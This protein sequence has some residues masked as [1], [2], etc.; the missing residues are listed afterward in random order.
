MGAE[1][2]S[3]VRSKTESLK[4]K[5]DEME[6]VEMG[7]D[8]HFTQLTFHLWFQTLL[9]TRNQSLMSKVKIRPCFPTL[10]APFRALR[11]R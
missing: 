11:F 10:S 2:Q 3:S 4:S 9:G 6:M 1:F 7:S 5:E 8:L